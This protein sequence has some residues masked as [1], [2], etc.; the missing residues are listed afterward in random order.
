M[1]KKKMLPFFAIA[2]PPPKNKMNYRDDSNLSSSHNSS[3]SIFYFLDLL[4][5]FTFH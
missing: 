3:V 2:E 1:E 4:L 5:K